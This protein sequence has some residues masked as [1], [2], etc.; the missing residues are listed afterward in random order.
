MDLFN[1][2][3]QV[4]RAKQMEERH[5]LAAEKDNV[6]EDKEPDEGDEIR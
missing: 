6:N 2:K 4:K 1:D 5:R 3:I